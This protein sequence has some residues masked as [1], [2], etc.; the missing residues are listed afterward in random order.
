MSTWVFLRGLTREQRHWGDFPDVF[1]QHMPDARVVLLDLPGNGRLNSQPSPWTVAAMAEHCRAELRR[2]GIPP[3]YQVLAMSLGA[4]VTAAWADAHP[5]E[6]SACVLINTSM[7]PFSPFYQRLRPRHYGLILRLMLTG[8]TP[9]RWEATVLRL[10][11]RHVRNCEQLLQD[12]VSYR[13]DA[14][15]SRANALRQ[16]W[17]AARFRASW[18]PPAARVLILASAQDGLVNPVCSRDL[19]EQWRCDIDMH[20]SAGHDIPLDDGPWVAQQVR[21]RFGMPL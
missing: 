2:Q 20:P 14:P 7:R 11:S 21:L 12:W 3:P 19:A 5:T 6:L 15:V 18:A 10:T 1:H 16:L 4:M 8:A 13:V 9:E 17:A